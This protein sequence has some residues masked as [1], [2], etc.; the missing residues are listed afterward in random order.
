MQQAFGFAA[1]DLVEWRARLARAHDSLRGPAG[2]MPRRRP[3]GQ[4]VKSLISSRT[5]DAVSL[6]AY[7]RLGS[8]WGNAAG[9]SRAVP[10]EIETVIR[11]VTF[12]DRKARQLPAALRMIGR[13]R[14]DFRLDFLGRWSVPDALAWLER[15]PGVGRKVAAATL[16]ASALR[17]PVLIV[18]SHVHRVCQRLGF[19]GPQATPAAVSERATA[20]LAAWDGEDFL[21][22]F[23]LMKRLGQHVCRFE[24]PDCP[25]CPLGPVCRTAQDGRR[26]SVGRI[27]MDGGRA[28]A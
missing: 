7:R 12:A 24:R 25:A 2:R 19:V 23:V 20:A 5:R 18:D 16:N 22:M 11:D 17:R 3:V 8:R 6:A 1:D 28:S 9:L 21:E 27:S 15:L 10:R 13:E 4:L 26:M 14:P